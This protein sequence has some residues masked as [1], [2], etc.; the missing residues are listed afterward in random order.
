M[1]DE[2]CSIF[3]DPNH[4]DVSTESRRS[5]ITTHP[6]KQRANGIATKESKAVNRLRATVLIV[7]QVAMVIVCLLVLVLSVSSIDEQMISQFVGQAEQIQ[8]AFQRIQSEKLGSIGALRVAAMAECTDRNLTWPTY[9]LSSFEKRATVAR[10]LSETIYIGLYPVVHDT[11]RS[12]WELYA[13][14][15][16]PRWM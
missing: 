5:S 14:Q 2:S 12:D 15:A 10:R 8:F 7:L 13:A 4:D 16:G 1:D 3:S 11:N 6:N 9:A